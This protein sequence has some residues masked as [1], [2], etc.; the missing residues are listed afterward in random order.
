MT[1]P[2]SP[3]FLIP[4]FPLLFPITNHRPPFVLNPII[5]IAKYQIQIPIIPNDQSQ[6]PIVFNDI[7]IYIYVIWQPPPAYICLIYNPEQLRVNNV[8][9]IISN[10]QWQIT[11]W[12]IIIFSN[13]QSQIPIIPN[14]QSLIT[15]IPNDQSL[16]FPMTNYRS[17][18][19]PMT[20]N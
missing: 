14:D 5:I 11:M 6:V 10:D 9:T 20:N 13:G 19:L 7:Y 16:Y 17:S 8:L 3:S 12:P 2:R 18:L 1:N 15:I 4:L